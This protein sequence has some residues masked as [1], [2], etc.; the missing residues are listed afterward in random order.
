M[1]KKWIIAPCASYFWIFRAIFVQFVYVQKKSKKNCKSCTTKGTG[2]SSRRG[3][4]NQIFIAFSVNVIYTRH[5]TNIFKAE[6]PENEGKTRLFFA[7]FALG[8][9][10]NL[11]TVRIFTKSPNCAFCRFFS[12]WQGKGDGVPFVGENGLRIWM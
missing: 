3:G 4:G 12:V 2:E 1:G 6:S 11:R 5:L 9:K 7:H 8:S 10:F